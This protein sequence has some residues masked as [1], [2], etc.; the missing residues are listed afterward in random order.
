ML[1]VF[2][3]EGLLAPRSI[4]KLGHPLSTIRDCLFDIFAATLHIWRPFPLS[5]PGDAPIRDDKDPFI[6]FLFQVSL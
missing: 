2:K 3:V 5:A 4:P 6:Q 1:G